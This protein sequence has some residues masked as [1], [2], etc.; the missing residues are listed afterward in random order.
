MC[1]LTLCVYIYIHTYIQ[2]TISDSKITAVFL[3]VDAKAQRLS[4]AKPHCRPRSVLSAAQGILRFTDRLAEGVVPL[5]Q[6]FNTIVISPRFHLSNPT[7]WEKDPWDGVT[8]SLDFEVLSTM[9]QMPIVWVSNV[10]Q[11]F[12]R[13]MLNRKYQEAF[14][15][16]LAGCGKATATLICPKLRFRTVSRVQGRNA[17]F[18]PTHKLFILYVPFN[19]RSF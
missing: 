19:T 6:A 11:G 5:K 2:V 14:S 16:V 17:T 3:S 18:C 12:G 7:R 9:L 1:C 13:N 8:E 4:D 10:I 15:P